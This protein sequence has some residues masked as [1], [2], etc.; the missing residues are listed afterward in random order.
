M[1]AY[2]QCSLFFFLML[3]TSDVQ[4]IAQTDWS[5]AL[6][7]QGD[8]LTSNTNYTKWTLQHGHDQDRFTLAQSGDIDN[9]M[10]STLSVTIDL[11]GEY[12]L[13]FFWKV[14]SEAKYD[15]LLFI[16]DG[17]KIRE[18][19]GDR[20]RSWTEI[21]YTL[22]SGMHKI[23]W[24]YLKDGS[25]TRNQDKGWICNITMPYGKCL[26]LDW[27][28]VF[29]FP[30]ND[31]SA[32][33]KTDAASHAEPWSLVRGTDVDGY[34]AQS[35]ELFSNQYTTLSVTFYTVQDI[36]LRFWW[37]V[38]SEK[39]RDELEFQ[40]DG[41]RQT[42][43]SGEQDWRMVYSTIDAGQ[44]TLYWKYSKDYSAVNGED[45]GWIYNIT[46][47]IGYCPILPTLSPSSAPTPSPTQIPNGVWL[48]SKNCA[49]GIIG[50]GF[51]N[52]FYVTIEEAKYECAQSCLER[53][54][55]FYADLYGTSTCYLH[56]EICGDWITSTNSRHQLWVRGGNFTY[57]DVG[58][59]KCTVH[60]GEDPIH[61][62]HH[63]AH[64][65]ERL[66]TLDPE[67]TGYSEAFSRNCLLWKE[68][69]IDYKPG[70]TWADA[71]C[72]KKKSLE[73]QICK[74]MDGKVCGM[75]FHWCKALVIT[76]SLSCSDFCT[77]RN[78]VCHNAWNDFDDGT[79]TERSQGNCHTT[80]YNQICQCGKYGSAVTEATT[81][82]AGAPFCEDTCRFANDGAC[83]DG[84]LG[85]SFSVC[86]CGTDCTDCGS[87]ICYGR[88]PN[89]FFTSSFDLSSESDYHT[90][91]RVFNFSTIELCADKCNHFFI[92]F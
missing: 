18:T 49:N 15:N 56:N 67:C 69:G 86:D 10:N 87:R 45:K 42:K 14:S 52:D 84:E 61:E 5:S 24:V 29:N 27:A 65:C 53:Y 6:G 83:D 17:T 76:N 36:C 26:E 60:G 50:T 55:C 58:K 54:D 23:E 9:N 44:H 91:T 48:K 62:Y 59:G 8:W 1:T 41:Q 38:S 80:A 78:L 40:V 31:S 66:C 74:D 4:V 35:G 25:V 30:A 46:S 63:E 72:M 92:N 12:C 57:I 71:H 28:A 22:G 85:S 11:R 37:K 34:V 2:D 39:M 75:G 82:G 81:P 90:P 19:S 77:A 32:E 7:L 47:S 3:T 89:G 70:E 64:G 43:I 73:D 79:C 20:N 51:V 13:H 33:W 88:C 68:Q 16:V 21:S